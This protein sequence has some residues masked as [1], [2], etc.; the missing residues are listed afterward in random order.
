MKKLYVALIPLMLALLFTAC[1]AEKEDKTEAE[2]T[3]VIKVEYIQ[4]SQ[5]EA[6]RIM[7]SE[8][9]IVILDVREQDEYDE[10]HIPGAVLLP[11]T[12]VDELAEEMLPDK[13]KTI[14][15]YCRS[16]RRSKVA[17][18]SLANLGYT[19]VREFGGI[20]DWPYEVTGNDQ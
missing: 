4:I 12:R 10:S 6:K 5:E 7:D 17:A 16:G 9:D 3:E 11:Y 18:T 8:E 1:A 19:D 13:N 20:I 14:L 15:V 2:E